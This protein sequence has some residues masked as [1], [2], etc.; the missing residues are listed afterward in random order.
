MD[1]Q[2]ANYKHYG[3]SLGVYDG[4]PFAVGGCC[5]NKEQLIIN[6]KEVEQLKDGWTSIGRFPFVSSSISFYSSVTLDNIL[7]I[8]G[9]YNSS[10]LSQL[11]LI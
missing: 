7:Y 11:E 4:S 8:F 9:K 3:T 2:S 1:E 10:V 6:N 5:D